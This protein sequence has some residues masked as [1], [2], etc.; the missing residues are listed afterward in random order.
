MWLKAGE[1]ITLN[2]TG[3]AA[4]ADRSGNNVNASQ[5]VT[6]SQPLLVSNAIKGN[7]A[8]RFDGAADYLTFPLPING[9]N[10][11]TIFLVSSC[12]TDR[13]GGSSNSETAAIFWNE[14]AWWGSTF[15][16]PFQSNAKFRFGTTQ[17]N[18]NP[19]YQWPASLGTGY[20]MTVSK[21]DSTVDSLYVN[22]SLVVSQSGKLATTAG[23]QNTGNLGLGYNNTFF[24]GDI[25]EVLVYQRALTDAE[26][27]T[28]EAYLRSKYF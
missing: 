28:V 25:A 9:L 27:Q 5:T 26:R 24:N 11:M 3:V 10:G 13:T 18:N 19:S 8:V 4:W 7:P 12:L 14:T 1:G 15:L 20:S 21:K 23:I 22:G 6:G 2:G 17:A 16:S